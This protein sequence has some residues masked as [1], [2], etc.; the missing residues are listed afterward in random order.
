MFKRLIYFLFAFVPFLSM[1]QS[2]DSQLTTQANVIRNEVNPAGNTKGRIAD[3][4]QALINSKQ[5]RLEQYVVSGT[6]TYTVTTTGTFVASYSSQI[7]V[8]K[9]TNANTGSGPFTLNVNS[10]GAKTIK[11]NTNVD[12]DAGDIKSGGVYILAYDG[13]NF[14]MIGGVG[15]G[16]SFTL[17]DGSG[18]TASGSAVNL[19]GQLNGDVLITDNLAGGHTVRIGGEADGDLR[20]PEIALTAGAIT[21]T[22]FEL[23]DNVNVDTYGNIIFNANSPSTGKSIQFNNVDGGKLLIN[24]AVTLPGTTAGPGK[25]RIHEDTDNG[26]DYTEFK[27]GSQLGNISYTLPVAA[28]TV[29]GY[30]LAGST[31]G[32]LS[33]V[34]QSGGG[35]LVDGDYGDITVG[36]TGTTM[37]VDNGVV[38]D[39]KIATHTTTKISTTNKSLLNSAIAYN[40][41]ANTYSDGTVQTFNPSNTN[42]G[43]V[44]GSNSSRPSSPIEGALFFNTT[45]KDVETYIDGSWTGITRGEDVLETT[46]AR[47]ITDADRNKT[48][49]CSNVGA[50]TITLNST[51][52]VGTGV[53]IFKAAGSGTITLSASGS[54]KAVDP[55]LLTDNAGA[56]VVHEG[57]GV[58]RAIGALGAGGGGSG[59]VESVTGDGVDNTDPANPVLSFP[60]ASSVV[61]TPAGNISATDAQ[62]AFNELD[63]EK[64]AVA[65]NLSD[66]SSAPTTLQNIGA[67]ASELEIEIV[68]GSRSLTS[69][70]FAPGNGGQV[71][72]LH[73]TGV[74]SQTITVP[75]DA[76]ETIPVG[77]IIYFRMTGTAGYLLS[78]AGPPSVNGT[79]GGLAGPGTGKLAALG[80]TAAN[81]WWFDNGDPLGSADQ[82]FR[83][84]AAGTSAGFGSIDLSKSAAVGSSILPIANG[85]TGS[86]TAPWWPLTGT[87]TLTGNVTM[88]GA[89]S[90]GYGVSPTSK[91]HLQGLSNGTASMF[92]LQNST[93]TVVLNITESGVTSQTASASGANALAFTY[94]PTMTYTANS[95]TQF[96]F[97]FNM[98]PVDGGFT[99]GTRSY[100][101]YRLNSSATPA[102]DFGVATFTSNA[103]TLWDFK[104]AGDQTLRN[105]TGALYLRGGSSSSTGLKFGTVFAS[106]TDNN[107]AFQYTSNIH[108]LATAVTRTFSAEVKDFTVTSVDGST[109]TYN[110]DNI[111]PTFTVGTSTL[112][113]RGPT[114]NP[115]ISGSGAI[116]HYAFRAISGLSGFGTATP[117]S[118]VDVQGSFS[119]AY[120][121]KTGAY[122]LTISD[123][124][125]EVTSGTH[126]QT[127][128]TAV[129]IA[130]RQYTITNSGSGIVTIATT[131]SQTFA[132]VTATPTTLTLIQFE[133]A[134]VVSNGTNWLKI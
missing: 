59:I 75:T 73:L 92:T 91:F 2:S 23:S 63:A 100:G 4:F 116:T 77:S 130:G 129:G 45:T 57:A 8:L 80:K 126:T 17:S 121:A 18:T 38:N 13:T 21:Q 83:M 39:A 32:V 117:T 10:L 64:L 120:V 70:D 71:K 109:I 119:T 101:R 98:I 82:I 22:D 114:W 93:P 20:V 56:W 66:I 25:L 34:A 118:T 35:G 14:Q 62:S 85:G 134:T 27:V 124:V 68:S 86:A 132:N 46:T 15:T 9:F 61:N 3:M 7:I 72:I 113:L 84:N 11:K 31:A 112:N 81:T 65:N 104:T 1:G 12:L 37:T 47:T 5:S 88:S 60:D 76:A 90:V 89:F 69:A 29:D 115:T 54:L 55:Q 127:L 36:G 49:I 50:I 96:G 67:Q 105:S 107:I 87:G 53:F 122:T 6:N 128:P 24:D 16:G 74:T 44:V 79:S 19:G 125:V 123:N 99:G 33:W 103:I 28:P 108:N 97:D 102:Y 43:L 111:I 26:T 106:S 52:E 51:P 30:V 95:Q 110:V 94:T 40:D 48:I 133:T 131:S 42:P 58:W 78:A 41:Q